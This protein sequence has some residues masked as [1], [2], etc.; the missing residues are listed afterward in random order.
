MAKRKLRARE[1]LK[2]D[3]LKLAEAGYDVSD[4]LPIGSV[5]GIPAIETRNVSYGRCD[6]Y[7]RFSKVGRQKIGSRAVGNARKGAPKGS[8]LVTKNGKT[9][10]S[11]G[12]TKSGGTSKEA[13][14]AQLEMQ[15]RRMRLLAKAGIADYLASGDS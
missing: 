8:L 12:L 6:R 10:Y 5:R 3:L 1:M 9:Y 2:R 4:T 13:A 11:E 15:A 7:E 14:E